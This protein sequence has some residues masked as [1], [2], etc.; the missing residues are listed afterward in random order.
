ME[1]YR[2]PAAAVRKRKQNVTRRFQP[3]FLR[4][5]DSASYS[6]GMNHVL[7][8]IT[9]MHWCSDF[10]PVAFSYLHASSKCANLGQ[11][12]RYAVLTGGLSSVPMHT[13]RQ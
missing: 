7:D 11:L 12:P 10:R 3:L 9:A 2:L 5:S 8:C 1:R 4:F 13:L 6:P